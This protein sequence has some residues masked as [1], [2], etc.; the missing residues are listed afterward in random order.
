M[1]SRHMNFRKIIIIKNLGGQPGFNLKDI[2]T[3]N[4]ISLQRILVVDDEE[5]IRQLYSDLLTGSGFEVDAASNGAVAWRAHQ[6]K[7]YDLLIT[8]NVM[9]KVSGIE[10]LGKIYDAGLTLP[11]IMV[12]GTP[13]MVQFDHRP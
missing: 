1:P 4:V 11:A 13:P 3:T 2:M 10:L 8:D 12:T 5:P 9:P 7:N 6:S